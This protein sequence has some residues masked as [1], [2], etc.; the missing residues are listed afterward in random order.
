MNRKL[1]FLLTLLVTTSLFAETQRYLIA[2]KK[3][4]ARSGLRVVSNSADAARHRVRTFANINA[5]AA[6]LTEE[7]AAAL[8]ASG[9]VE[10]VEPSVKRYALEMPRPPFKTQTDVGLKYLNQITPWGMPIVHAKDVWTATRGQNVNV[11]VLDTGI[12]LQHPDLMQAYAG[13]YNVYAPAEP[14][15]DDNKHGTH[16]AGIIAATD[17]AFGTVGIAPGVKLWAVKV[18]NIR[19]EGY[20]DEIVAGLDWVISKAKQTGGRWVINMSIGS[21]TRS[22][23]EERAIY[24]ALENGILVVAAAGNRDR[25]TLDYPGRYQAVLAVGA[26]DNAG[27]KADFSS[28]GIGLS[29]MAPGVDIPSTVIEGVNES[30]DVQLSPNA[31]YNA[32]G[33]TGSP[34]A[35]IT[36]QIVDCGLGYPEDFPSTVA[37]RIA[38]VK[39]GEIKFREKAKNAKNAGAS[40]IIIY[41]ND[42]ATNTNWNM[43]FMTCKDGVCEYDPGW[44]NYQFILSIGVSLVDGEKLKAIAGTTATAAFRSEKYLELSGTSMATPHVTAIASLLLSLD[45][46]LTPSDLRWALES[47]AQDKLEPGWDMQTGWGVADALAAAKHVAPHKFGLPQQNQP[48]R[49]QSVRH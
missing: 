10:I 40:A 38:L 33:I 11:A 39:R 13:G 19:G 47:T 30:A 26:L 45:S 24:E 23:I 36:G 22:S 31:A 16:V 2:T 28:Y 5:F 41:N 12:D 35:T 6:D 43:D 1:V 4:P 42:D 46:S 3:S 20:S 27:N 34:Y 29:V 37:G 14:P 8:R 49:R 48:P 9:E 18:L 25:D 21:R 7:E 15:Q 32:W 17:N 44:E